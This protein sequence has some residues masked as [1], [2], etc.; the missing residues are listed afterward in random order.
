MDIGRT[1]RKIRV[2]RPAD[3][4]SSWVFGTDLGVERYSQTD[5]DRYNDI[6]IDIDIGLGVQN[7]ESM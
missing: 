1:Q 4:H 2:S 6:D 3:I 7:K 5:G